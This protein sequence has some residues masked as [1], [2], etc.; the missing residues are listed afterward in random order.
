[1]LEERELLA[2]VGMVASKVHPLIAMNA[3]NRRV[4]VHLQY[5]KDRNSLLSRVPLLIRSIS[6]RIE[7]T[8]ALGCSETLRESKALGSSEALRS[9]EALGRSKTASEWW[10]TTESTAEA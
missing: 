7:L 9:S 10:H 6:L 5:N 1:M 4:V 2:V 3:L 8:E